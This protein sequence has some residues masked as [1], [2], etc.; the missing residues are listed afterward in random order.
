MANAVSAN[1][2]GDNPKMKSDA[3]KTE[4]K[5]A[6]VGTVVVEFDSGVKNANGSLDCSVN[7]SACHIKMIIS[8]NNVIPINPP[9]FNP[10]VGAQLAVLIDEIDF[11]EH[12]AT[13][14]IKALTVEVPNG[15]GGVDV[16][17][18]P[19]QNSY[20]SE[21]NQGYMIYHN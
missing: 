2:L 20:Y 3:S 14:W 21:E 5:A 6:K 16:W 9:G 10:P 11:P 4:I 15:S 17:E 13:V 12:P 18:I 8:A 7:G 1:S 19:A